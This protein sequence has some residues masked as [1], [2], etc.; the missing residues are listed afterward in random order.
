MGALLDAISLAKGGVPRHTAVLK[1]GY[2]LDADAAD[3]PLSVWP[4]GTLFVPPS[5]AAAPSI[6]STGVGDAPGGAGAHRIRVSYLGDDWRFNFYEVDLNG[7]TPVVLPFLAWR[8]NRVRVLSAGALNSLEGTLSVNIG[9]TL[10]VS[11]L[12]GQSSTNKAA[13]SVGRDELA[14]LFAVTTS[15]QKVV[16]GASAAQASFGVKIHTGVDDPLT[17]VSKTRYAFG[18]V[19]EGQNYF[20]SE[21]PVPG[22]IVGPADVDLVCSLITDNNMNISSSFRVLFEDLRGS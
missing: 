21:I 1:Y 12:P 5:A 16:G 11:M 14:H 8:V 3:T 6:V 4:P 19:L 10:V 18:L 20:A 2:V 7:T 9:P 13:F 17:S 22:T 15:I